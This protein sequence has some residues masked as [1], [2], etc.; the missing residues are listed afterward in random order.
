[1]SPNINAKPKPADVDL[2]A[3]PLALEPHL[4]APTDLPPTGQ[5]PDDADTIANPAALAARLTGS[6]DVRRQGAHMIAAG[7][8]AE[9]VAAAVEQTETY[10]RAV[11]GLLR[12]V[13]G[14]L[15][16]RDGAH[17]ALRDAN[18]HLARIEQG[19]A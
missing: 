2:L 16:D 7:A 10:A 19:D 8:P 12:A 5:L 1:M 15:S 3:G 18:A 13:D 6:A 11:A 4:P 9:R 14:V 17:A